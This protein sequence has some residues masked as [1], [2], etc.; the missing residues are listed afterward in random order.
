MPVII[1]VIEGF[2]IRT[3]YVDV[4]RAGMEQVVDWTSLWF[5][6]FIK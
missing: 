4:E 3:V 1:I 2:K 5:K 6:L